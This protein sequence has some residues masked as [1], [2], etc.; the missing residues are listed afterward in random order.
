[1]RPDP[2]AISN[3]RVDSNPRISADDRAAT[4]DDTT[5]Y[6]G[7]SRHTHVVA[8]RDTVIYLDVV[9]DDSRRYSSVLD[10]RQGA[11]FYMG[12]DDDASQMRD[13]G[14]VAGFVAHKTKTLGAN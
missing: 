6:A 2:S 1:M 9:L 8:D 11:D 13:P 4:D 10:E 14:F 12:T 3:A 5:R 7:A